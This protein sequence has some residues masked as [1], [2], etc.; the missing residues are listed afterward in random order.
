[1]DLGTLQKLGA[2]VRSLPLSLKMLLVMLSLGL[3]PLLVYGYISQR[4]AL[5]TMTQEM[6]GHIFSDAQELASLIDRISDDE[7]KE[8]SAVTEYPA[9]TSFADNPSSPQEAEKALT[10]LKTLKSM[11]KHLRSIFLVDASTGT[12]VLSTTGDRGR[13]LGNRA[14]IKNAAA[15]EANM[16]G[17][18]R[19][20][21]QDFIY[22][23]APVR[24]SDGRVAYVL[25]EDVDANTLWELLREQRG[26]GSDSSV[27]VLTDEFGV[28]IGH[29]SNPSLVYKSWAPL[30][31]EIKQKLLQEQ[32]YGADITDIE[33]TDFPEIAAA[34]T[35]TEPPSNLEHKLAIS[36][37]TFEAGIAR[38]SFLEWTVMESI[39]LSTFLAPSDALRNRLLVIIAVTAVTLGL[40]TFVI[41]RIPL[42]PL[43]QLASSVQHMSNGDF[44]TPVPDMPDSEMH[45]LAEGFDIMRQKVSESY[46]ELQR[47]YIDMA[48]AL[49][50]SLEARDPYTAGH[51]ERV[52]HFALALCRKLGVNEIEVDKIRRAAELHDIGKACV[53]DSVLLKPDRLSPGE[54]AE[55]KRHPAKSG[56]IVHHLGFLRDV[57]PLIEGHHERYDGGG[58]PKGL[59]GPEIPIGARILAVADAYDA[60]TSN[61]AY[62]DALSHE[63]AI[64]IL[65]E[66]AGTQWDA[67]IIKAFLE[68]LEDEQTAA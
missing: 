40:L 14:F 9:L 16:S 17:P 55:I 57:V 61:R 12:V 50:A 53:S 68:M 18:A 39:P 28:R 63:Q 66:G 4:T 2:W 26:L 42:K 3:V 10:T 54:F 11:H 5:S 60:M 51:T 58:Y 7:L 41:S 36:A 59:T 47:G 45:V 30:P 24:S 34:V 29:S 44:A 67:M 22:Y 37:E 35:A 56:E 27:T 21:G 8:V 46:R 13:Y 64:E 49:V 25:G 31:G 23:A 19:D 43:R 65:E 48:R 32:R 1:M 62:R 38:G 20:G 6:R 33:A 15:G 52:G